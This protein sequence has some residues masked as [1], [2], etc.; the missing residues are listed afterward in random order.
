MAA[1]L[2]FVKTGSVHGQGGFSY[3]KSNL[4]IEQ[5]HTKCFEWTLIKMVTVYNKIQKQ[6]GSVPQVKCQ[7]D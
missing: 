3:S 5:A 1:L 2:E 7:I 4:Q 6:R